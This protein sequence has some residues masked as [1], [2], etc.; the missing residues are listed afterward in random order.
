MLELG[1]FPTRLLGVMLRV[2]EPL[3]DPRPR[4]SPLPSLRVGRLRCTPPMAGPPYPCQRP[5]LATAAAA[6]EEEEEEEEEGEGAAAAGGACRRHAR[7]DRWG[8]TR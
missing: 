1:R 4:R 3:P 7:R 8:H 5:R 2:Q 6:A